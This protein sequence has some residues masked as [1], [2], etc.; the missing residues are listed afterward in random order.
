MDRQ[1]FPLDA[2]GRTSVQSAFPAKMKSCGYAI[3]VS[4]LMIH[5]V[6]LVIKDQRLKGITA[7]YDCV[8]FVTFSMVL[9]GLFCIYLLLSV[10]FFVHLFYC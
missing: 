1:R 2:L 8:F 9:N 7:W 6:Q 10:I 5:R 4:R 3:S